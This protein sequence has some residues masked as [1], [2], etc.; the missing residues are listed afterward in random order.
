[1]RR[2][3]IGVTLVATV[4]MVTALL[5]AAPASAAVVQ[6]LSYGAPNLPAIPVGDI[7]TSPLAAPATFTVAPGSP[8]GTKCAASALTDQVLTN[9][10]IPGV[11]NTR[12]ITQT[13]GG[14]TS[15]IPGVT[16]VLGVVV[17]N[18]PNALMFSDAAGL[19]VTI[20]PMAGPLQV[21]ITVNP[22][23]AACVWQANAGAY[24]GNYGNPLHQIT[25]VNQPMHLVAGPGA[26]C[27]GGA[28][29]ISW[30]Y[31]PVIDS[32]QIGANQV[33]VN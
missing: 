15:T 4:A 2:I 23:A 6:V 17:N 21:T 27:G 8:I 24:H 1:M 22:G 14:C 13:F 28:D 26:L 7:L 31:G 3:R 20:A 19:P 12:I 5:P 33:F 32:S 30:T 11:A 25:L 10:P 9:P 16:A 18:L 29:F